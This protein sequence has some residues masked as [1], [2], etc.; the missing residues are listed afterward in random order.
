MQQKPQI[1]TVWQDFIKAAIPVL[2]N[3]PRKQKFFIADRMLNL[4]LDIYER[5]LEATY[6]NVEEKRKSLQNVNLNLEK[7]RF[8][9]RLSFD[10]LLISSGQYKIFS[11]KI[12]ETG[13]MA[14]GWYKSLSINPANSNNNPSRVQNP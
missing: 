8:Y 1:L 14:G 4:I 13:R 10:L 6:G 11:E 2:E 3:F 7:L 5:L 9:V 12:N